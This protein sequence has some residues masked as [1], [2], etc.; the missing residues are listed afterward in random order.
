M[1]LLTEN[2]LFSLTTTEPRLFSIVVPPMGPRAAAR[3]MDYIK[4][5]VQQ[6]AATA[7]ANMQGMYAN[8]LGELSAPHLQGGGFRLYFGITDDGRTVYRTMANEER[9]SLL[10]VDRRFY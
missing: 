3:H 5:A 8:M 9:D 10:V 7:P 4:D 2:E 1:E 6:E